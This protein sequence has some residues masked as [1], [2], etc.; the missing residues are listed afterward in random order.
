MF[1]GRT[2]LGSSSS[3]MKVTPSEPI[4]IHVQKAGSEAKFWVGAE[5]VLDRSDGVDA[6]TLRKLLVIVQGNRNIIEDTWNEYFG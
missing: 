2:D 1:L 3:L 4:H 5:I 6:K